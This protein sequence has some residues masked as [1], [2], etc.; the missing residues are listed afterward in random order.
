MCLYRNSLLIDY[1][2]AN[3]ILDL[4]HRKGHATTLIEDNACD[5]RIALPN[6]LSLAVDSVV[7]ETSALSSCLKGEAEEATELNCVSDR[8][9]TINVS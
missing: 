9:H 3:L 5:Q 8:L 7:I 1:N 4:V 2:D 6:V